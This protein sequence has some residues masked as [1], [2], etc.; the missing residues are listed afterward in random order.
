MHGEIIQ[1]EARGW[2][3]ANPAATGSSVITSMPDVSELPALGFEGWRSW[4]VEA[5]RDVLRWLPPA[6]VAIFYQSDIRHQGVWIDKSY[7]LMQAADAERAPLLWHKIVCRKPPGTLAVGRASYSHM[8]CFG[9]E[10]Q[11]REQQFGP[12]VLAD[13]GASPWTRGMGQH[14]CRLACDYLRQ[15]TDTT[16]VL[17]PFCGRGSVLGVAL[18]VGFDVIGVELHA[19]RCR[20]ARSVITA[21]GRAPRR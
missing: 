8:L 21:A 20:A 18:E 7:L 4:F 10:G 19:R 17:D 11:V 1:A 9:R 2:L 12:D 14:A 6:G 5:A 13:A 16:L 15:V 3:A